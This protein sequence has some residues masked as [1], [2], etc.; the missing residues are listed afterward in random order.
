MV[1]FNNDFSNRIS[2]L[3]IG[4][5]LAVNEH[6]NRLNAIIFYETICHQTIFE[7]HPDDLILSSK[8]LKIISINF[9]K[10]SDNDQ[11]GKFVLGSEF[12]P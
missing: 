3:N 7:I 10:S 2:S 4:E 8:K 9:Q 6:K 11:G 12:G 1:K 5:Y